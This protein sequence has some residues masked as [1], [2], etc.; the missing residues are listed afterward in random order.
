MGFRS[1]G[2]KEID[3]IKS[4]I[5]D[6]LAEKSICYV[7]LFEL[8]R[9]YELN[10]Y[11][12]FKDLLNDICEDELKYSIEL[13]DKSVGFFPKMI[14]S[15][16]VHLHQKD[17]Y[18]L[19]YA[20]VT[21]LKLLLSL[22]MCKEDVEFIGHWGKE[23]HIYAID[24]EEY[25]HFIVEKDG[26]SIAYITCA[27]H[28]KE[29]H[30][31]AIKRIKTSNQG[32]GFGSHAISALTEYLYNTLHIHRVRS[33]LHINHKRVKFFFEQLGFKEEGVLRDVIYLND[34]YHSVYRM[35]KL[36]TD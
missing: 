35:A 20:D 18:A 27:E 2:Q 31:I 11:E 15:H 13:Q 34:E 16:N 23:D 19:R 33:D 14:E 6:H 26:L 5:K 24:N 22:E 8:K 28:K 9:I 36:V 3:K 17:E 7:S 4:F 25:Y 12:V 10:R 21:D 1:M 29:N 30:S 32:Q